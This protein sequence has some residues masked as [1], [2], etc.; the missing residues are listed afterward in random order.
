M[1]PLARFLLMR[2]LFLGA[3][4]VWAED[5]LSI[6]LLGQLFGS[7]DQHFNVDDG[8][9]SVLF[10]VFNSSIIMFATFFVSVMVMQGVVGTASQGSLM[11]KKMGQ[12][13]Y[14]MFFRSGSAMAMV[15]P[16]YNGYSLIQVFVMSIV[17]HSVGN[18]GDISQMIIRQTMNS[19]DLE[20]GGTNAAQD[21]PNMQ[22]SLNKSK[23]LSGYT[24]TG[25]YENL[26][27]GMLEAFQYQEDRRSPDDFSQPLYR[28]KSGSEA[29]RP[30][31]ALIFNKKDPSEYDA[32]TMV[33]QK[34]QGLSPDAW[35]SIQKRIMLAAS[36]VQNAIS[37]EG[38]IIAAAPSDA[39][40]KREC[41]VDSGSNVNP[42]LNNLWKS[43]ISKHRAQSFVHPLSPEE[44][45]VVKPVQAFW[46]DW[47][48]FPILYQA[49]QDLRAEGITVTSMDGLFQKAF[50][51]SL[52]KASE[53]QKTYSSFTQN[54]DVGGFVKI[55]GEKNN[56]EVGLSADLFRDIV[57]LG[58]EKDDH[59]LRA[60]VIVANH[61]KKLLLTVSIPT[62]VCDVTTVTNHDTCGVQ[63]LALTDS[64]TSLVN[65]WN[66]GN[67]QKYKLTSVNSAEAERVAMQAPITA[68]VKSTGS[69]WI[70]TF[71]GID[72]KAAKVSVAP[73]S[74]MTEM[75]TQFSTDSLLFMFT[76]SR[77]VKQEQMKLAANTFWSF[78]LQ[79]MGL[80]AGSALTEVMVT[81]SW[82]H[83]NCL[84]VSV[85]PGIGSTLRRPICSPMLIG[86][87]PF[88]GYPAEMGVA[89]AKV[90]ITGAA[91]TATQV[92]NQVLMAKFDKDWQLQTQFAYNK[93]GYV[94]TAAIPMMVISN[95]LAIWLPMLPTLVFYIAVIGWVLAVIE[96]MV[97]SPLVLLG[98]TFPHGH[99]FLGS[100]QQTMIVLL[101]V[102]IRAPL[103]VIGYYAGMVI[104]ALGMQLLS[105]GI[106]PLV[107][108]RFASSDTLP[109][110][111]AFM[112]YAFMLIVLYITGTL[113]TQAISFTYKL[114]N[115]ILAW[116]GGQ[117]MD[118][119]ETAAV[120]QLQNAVNAQQ[121]GAL[122]SIR[123][124]GMAGGQDSSYG[125]A[126]AGASKAQNLR[127]G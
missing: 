108:G 30:T 16:V 91:N 48:Y 126:S 52:K 118:G 44:V 66:A 21:D 97:A 35:S 89:V 90:A 37:R 42:C 82:D 54:L 110:H 27:S 56:D 120:M 53:K 24:A 103:I 96:A 71:I 111:E 80:M 60:E 105:H 40:Q 31:L 106:V 83:M 125:S 26:I 73:I 47:I 18:A 84:T 76:L 92:S 114:P 8:L 28:I 77:N 43:L 36:E 51:T 119:V 29:G 75:A 102:Y 32:T 109:L 6:E 22:T 55:L 4:C 67:A 115:A 78:F 15:Y 81:N 85:Q 20:L 14:F 79:Q 93:Y 95:L 116:V 64:E 112:L 46:R 49:S 33:F 58:D 99:D 45:I 69:K 50:P 72:G 124:A 13:S 74:A 117:R 34:P 5:G 70:E 1:K 87:L 62:V 38:C 2:A 39:S 68:F 59:S 11:G 94:V 7:V 61:L 9:A 57:D 12:S 121:K 101:G 100:A 98:M 3:C 122:G 17:M 113:L 127:G 104:L 86:P 19:T 63:S 65:L 23:L 88:P 10:Q 25:F 41:N 123:E 107:I